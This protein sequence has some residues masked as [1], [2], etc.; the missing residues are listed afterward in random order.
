MMDNRAIDSLGPFT[1]KCQKWIEAK[2]AVPTRCCV[3]VVRLPLSTPPSYVT[4]SLAM[5][6][7]CPPS[8]SPPRLM[9]QS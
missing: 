2:M 8:P 9:Q 6:S 4:C 1:I 5:R 3:A 7:S